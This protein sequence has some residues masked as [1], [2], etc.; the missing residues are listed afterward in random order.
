MRWRDLWDTE[1]KLVDAN[2]VELARVQKEGIGW[3]AYV[4]ERR[5]GEVSSSRESGKAA[6]ARFQS[7][8]RI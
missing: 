2:G 5:L 7:G 6:V 4:G 3:I 8:A 1:S